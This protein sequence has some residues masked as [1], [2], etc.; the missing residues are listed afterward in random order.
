MIHHIRPWEIF[1]KLGGEREVV[2]KIPN[3]SGIETE[4]ISSLDT[5]LLIAVSRSQYVFT[6]LE[7]GTGCG[8]TTWHLA[9]NVRCSILTVDNNDN[10]R[11]FHHTPEQN[12]IIEIRRDL[13]T[14]YP[15]K[16]NIVF[17]DINYSLETVQTSTD[18]AFR[19]DPKVV[20][21]HDWNLPHVQQHL[22]MID[23]DL[24]HV[25]ESNMTFWFQGGLK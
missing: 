15:T 20:A 16:F 12:H 6:A 13:A 9:K 7:L 25:E 19:C 18:L 14:I 22:H 8:Y 3:G 2:L 17:C 21:W 23:R 11:I 4:T 1:K 5:L 10:A 24:Y